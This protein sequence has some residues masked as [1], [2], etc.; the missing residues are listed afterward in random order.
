MPRGDEAEN[1]ALTIG[2]VAGFGDFTNRGVSY[3]NGRIY[4]ATTDGRLIAVDAN[5][6]IPVEDFGDLSQAGIGEMV[7]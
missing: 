4:F 6:G 5:S 3:W 2:I 1:D 7:F